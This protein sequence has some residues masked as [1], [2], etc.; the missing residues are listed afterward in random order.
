MFSANPIT[1]ARKPIILGIAN[2]A[3]IALY[4]YLSARTW[5]PSHERGHDL[6]MSGGDSIY[7]TL[8]AL[9]VLISFFI[10]NVSWAIYRVANK[11]KTG[12]NR[13]LIPFG[14][15]GFCWV[16]AVLFDQHRQS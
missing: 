8:T 1:K 14:L 13:V 7:W 10:L 3:G 6:P 2:G 15:I 16:V 11:S 4:L 12:D 9:P 5:L